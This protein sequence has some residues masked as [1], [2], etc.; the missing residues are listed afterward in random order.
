MIVPVTGAGLLI[1][2][3]TSFLLTGI[4]QEPFILFI[5][6]STDEYCQY[7]KKGDLV[8][9]SAPEGG[10]LRQA[11]I[12]L[13]L[14]ITWHTPLLVLPSGH[15][16]SSRLLMVVSAGDQ[17]IMSCS[18]ER[19][20]HPEQTVICSS[21]ELAGMELRSHPDGIEI[22]RLPPETKLWQVFPDGRCESIL[23]N[24]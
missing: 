2:A 20:T 1:Q 4:V 17:I 11:M 9:I 13:E 23:F 6:T 5:E 21:E 7:L 19:G 16:G 8:T 10:E 22:R 3:P 12:L 24:L 15:P 18:I 14:V